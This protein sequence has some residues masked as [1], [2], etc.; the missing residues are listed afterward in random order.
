MTTITLPWPPSVN[1]YWRMWRGRMLIS[2][3]GRAFRKSVC[4]AL[5]QLGMQ[6]L[7]GPLAVAIELH[8]PDR[9]RR[10]ADN[11]QK[12]TLDALQHGGAFHDDSQ[13]FWLLTKKGV[14]VPGGK[15]VVRIAEGSAAELGFPPAEPLCMN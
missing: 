7:S 1:H 11:S 2:R 5:A 4:A 6:P 14:V 3:E 15:V 13:V 10:D 12:A 9:R 8:P